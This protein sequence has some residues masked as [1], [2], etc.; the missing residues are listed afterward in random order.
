MRAMRPNKLNYADEQKY[1]QHQYH[2]L[3]AVRLAVKSYSHASSH[4]VIAEAIVMRDV[5]IP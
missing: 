1:D 2:S 3:I 4:S 5:W